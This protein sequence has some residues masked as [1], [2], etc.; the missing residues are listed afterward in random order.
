MNQPTQLNQ[1]VTELAVVGKDN[2]L[3]QT[4]VEVL[5]SNFGE[6]YGKA[7]VLAAGATDIVVT[8]EDQTALMH[9]ARTK[10]LALKAVRV[11]VEST[12]KTLKEQ[13]LREGKAIDGMANIIKALIVP[14]EE[15]LEN[16]EKFAEI[17]QAERKAARHAERI[18]KLSKYVPDV[19]LYSLDDMTDETFEN[20]VASSKEAFEAQEAAK[21]KA[22]AERIAQEKAAAEE[23]ER[24][25]QENIKLREEA[26]EREAAIEAERQKRL[27]VER[28]AAE[29]AAA[30]AAQTAEVE[31]AAR[32]ALLAPDKEKLLALALAIESLELPAVASQE[33][34]NLL[35]E[36]RDFLARISKNLRI[37][38]E[39]L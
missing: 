29:K 25:R 16:Q 24:I 38:A 5:L 34:G 12:R 7:K 36:T 21:A 2:G 14:V 35:D 33:A 19:S 4:K 27:A 11:E 31:E 6:A 26:A 18:E 37:K 8:E 1:E 15:H 32:K 23:Q 3:E 9:E 10:R 13:S 30:E 39:E 17:K 20:L 22:E 28:E